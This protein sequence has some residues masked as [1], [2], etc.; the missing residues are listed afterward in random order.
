[1]SAQT[2]PISI[3]TAATDSSNS[4][5]NLSKQY[6]IG[7]NIYNN[8]KNLPKID[9]IPLARSDS[10]SYHEYNRNTLIN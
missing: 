10:Q 1:L 8:N 4:K 3:A 5:L 2:A 9:K 6:A 7:N